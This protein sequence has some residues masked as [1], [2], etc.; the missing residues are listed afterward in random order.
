MF[1]KATLD[2]STKQ[3]VVLAITRSRLPTD[4]Q[5][6]SLQQYAAPTSPKQPAPEL[7]GQIRLTGRQVAITFRVEVPPTTPLTDNVYIATDSSG[8]QPNAYRMDRIDAIHYRL[9][10]NFTSG[11]KF[12]Y[13]YTRGSWNSVELAKSGLQRDARPY[14]VKEVDAK[15]E[16]DT[17]YGW[18]DQ[19]A[20][21]QN[22][23]PNAIPTLF[24]P[25]GNTGFP[26]GTGGLP[27]PNKTLTPGGLPPG[28]ANPSCTKKP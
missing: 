24:N 16:D 28:C 20:N 10:R 4:A 18:S 17:V 12:A 22:A 15:V 25:L 6:A 11:T 21:Q 27:Q 8:W 13:K 3:I 23:G 2:P 14:F 19:Q 9:T 5:F 26:P 7:A 1:A